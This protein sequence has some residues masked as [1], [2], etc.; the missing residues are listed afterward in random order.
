MKIYRYQDSRKNDIFT[1]WFFSLEEA[2]EEA[3]NDLAYMTADEKNDSELEITG[4]E[5]SV[6]AYA[7]TAEQLVEDLRNGEIECPEWDPV[8]MFKDGAIC[9][10]ETVREENA[11]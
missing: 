7:G 4:Y 3:E 11:T 9:H 6:D 1:K 8:I 5:I 2:R 10:S